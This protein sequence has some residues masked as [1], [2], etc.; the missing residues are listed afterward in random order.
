MKVIVNSNENWATTR[1]N[2][3]AKVHVGPRLSASVVFNSSATYLE[4]QAFVQRLNAS[5]LFSG[6][7]SE[8]NAV[9]EDLAVVEH[10]C[11]DLET[12]NFRLSPFSVYSENRAVLK[13]IAIALTCDKTPLA[14]ISKWQR[15]RY[16]IENNTLIRE[17]PEMPYTNGPYDWS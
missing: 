17:F 6:H 15:I 16:V 4:V 2:Y 10:W 8:V 9:P 3:M 1:H 12:G 13:A 11:L 14:K 7:V 5:D